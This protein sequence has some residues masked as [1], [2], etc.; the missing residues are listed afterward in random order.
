MNKACF[1]YKTNSANSLTRGRNNKER[2]QKIYKKNI[3][4]ENY[5]NFF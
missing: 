3:E 2:L 1:N 5:F 4:S